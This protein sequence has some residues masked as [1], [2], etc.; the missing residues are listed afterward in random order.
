MALLFCCGFDSA[1]WDQAALDDLSDGVTGGGGDIVAS[2]GPYATGVW[3]KGTGIVE[4]SFDI[5]QGTTIRTGFWLYIVSLTGVAN[6]NFSIR[7]HAGTGG[8]GNEL[9]RFLVG[10]TG[11]SHSGELASVENDSTKHW[12]GYTISAATWHWLEFEIVVS[13]TVGTMKI[14]HN[15]VLVNTE[16]GLD[17]AGTDTSGPVS[18][19]YHN[20]WT[21]TYYLDDL[22]IWDDSGPVMN[23]ANIGAIRI[24]PTLADG[25]GST[26]DW[27][28]LGAGTN[29][30]EV[31]EAI[32]DE[33]TS[34]NA[35]STTNDRDELDLAAPSG[36][37]FLGCSVHVQA[38]RVDAG[39]G[40]MKVGIKRSTS[41]STTNTSLADSAGYK[42]CS[43]YTSVDPSTGAA[44]DATGAAA[45]QVIYENAG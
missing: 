45:A 18:V 29:F 15:G 21:Q 12:S 23:G 10:N 41:E 33:D 9:C 26:T 35:S 2:L 11:D 16:T 32:A 39:T 36:D 4:R 25:D 7:F 28:P 31:D 40:T 1:H 22:V 42:Y 24:R 20:H 5:T 27:A 8:T 13:A 17:T 37:G 43:H 6:E 19:M 30:S 34:Y 44:W 14:W 3:R 38:K